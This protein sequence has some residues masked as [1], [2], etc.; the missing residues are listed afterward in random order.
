MPRKLFQ[1]ATILSLLLGIVVVLLWIRSYGGSD[2]VER[3]KPLG[4]SPGLISQEILGLQ[5]TRGELLLIFGRHSL[6]PPHDWQG[7]PGQ[8]KPRVF[9]SWGRLGKGHLGWD[10]PPP[11]QSWWNRLGFA[12]YEDGTSASFYDE[13]R[14][15]MAMPM[16]VLVVACSLLPAAWL[17]GV[18]RR[19]RRRAAGCC[20][21]CGYDLRATPQRC[22]ECGA[23]SS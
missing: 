20:Q 17:Y 13:S 2:Y 4:E 3:M 16:W 6:Y 23:T 22:P 1:A 14:H 7:T 15:I 5:C 12:I 8:P 9:W 21:R 11:A 10:G 18:V 19:R